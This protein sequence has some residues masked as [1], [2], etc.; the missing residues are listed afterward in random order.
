MKGIRCGLFDATFNGKILEAINA[1]EKNIEGTT[2]QAGA[3]VDQVSVS[4]FGCLPNEVPKAHHTAGRVNTFIRRL[5]KVASAIH[6]GKVSSKLAELLYPTESLGERAPQVAKLTQNFLEISHFYKGHETTHDAAFRGILD[7]V[8]SYAANK[9]L[10][11]KGVNMKKAVR[12][13]EKIEED[14]AFYNE[15]MTS[16]DIAAAN[17]YADLK[18]KKMKLMRSTEGRVLEEMISKI[19]NDIPK[20]ARQLEHEKYLAKRSPGRT[21]SFE[22][23]DNIGRITD[24][25]FMKK[26]LVGY[27]NL[28]SDMHSVLRNGVKSYISVVKLAVGHKIPEDKIKDFERSIWEGLGI[29]PN[30]PADPSYYPHFRTD[31]NMRE[32]QD[33]AYQMQTMLDA[34]TPAISNNGSGVLEALENFTTYMSGHAKKREFT[35]AEKDTFSKNFLGNV[36]RYVNEVDRF[37]YISRMGEARQ[38]MLKEAIDIYRAGDDL[39]GYGANVARVIVDL[40]KTATGGDEIADPNV[41]NMLDTLLAL[42]FTSKLGFNV[43]T[44]ARNAG[45]RL[46]NFVE[47][48]RHITKQSKQFYKDKTNIRDIVDSY[49]QEAGFLFSE[50]SPELMES[51]TTSKNIRQRIRFNEEG[52]I[53]YIN[54]MELTTGRVA[55]LAKNVAGKSGV[56]MREI[57]N[58]NRKSTFKIAFYRTYTDLTNDAAFNKR[59]GANAEKVAIERAKKAA[60]NKTIMLHF[61]YSN[62]S[63]SKILRGP[64]GKALFQFQHYA[65]KFFELNKKYYDEA[66]DDIKAGDIGGDRAWRAY[67]MGIAYFAVPAALSAITGINWGNLI[68]HSTAKSLQQ[69]LS[70]FSGDKDEIDK[71]FYGSG[72]LTGLIGMPLVSDIL[73]LGEI[74]EFTKMD[75]D[76]L[77]AMLIGYQDYANASGDKRAYDIIRMINTALGRGYTQ[78]IPMLFSGNLGMALQSELSLYPSSKEMKKRTNLRESLPDETQAMIDE[79][80]KEVEEHRKN[81]LQQL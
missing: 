55:S 49:M 40:H 25:P 3:I 42:E 58:M 4:V 50:Y 32:M 29:K 16:G 78:T 65:F 9:F 22:L 79:L 70:L 5:E 59:H 1:F 48:G 39:N 47:F 31:L 77:G 6:S 35:E 43:R 27:V 41:Q 68:E 15:K 17:K 19:E 76:S 23:V 62:F 81:A 28:M 71:A 2:M 52:E 80:L 13:L 33:L 26:A 18:D 37:N 69:V 67:R 60:L 46:L 64:V 74:T 30:G 12:A 11:G 51:V 24:D 14:L 66:R 56:F 8:G 36:K 57:E 7:N 21:G 45:Q 20:L 10:A 63:K 72:P 73:R 53:E 54:P 34:V 75:E 38:K 61:D 44:A